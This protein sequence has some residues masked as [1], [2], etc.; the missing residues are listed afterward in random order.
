M[1][2][3]LLKMSPRHPIYVYIFTHHCY[4]VPLSLINLSSHHAS[5]Y[6]V[7]IRATLR[8]MLDIQVYCLVCCCFNN[9]LLTLT[10]R[11]ILGLYRS[12]HSSDNQLFFSDFLTTWNNNPLHFWPLYNNVQSSCLNSENCAALQFDTVFSLQSHFCSVC[13]CFDRKWNCKGLKCLY[14]SCQ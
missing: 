2:V 14:K 11:K 9:Q 6:R 12:F 3:T 4:I 1:H 10:L 7:T 5:P 13:K 8:E